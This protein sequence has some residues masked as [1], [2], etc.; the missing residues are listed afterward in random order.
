MS[1]RVSRNPVRSPE[2]LGDSSNETGNGRDFRASVTLLARGSCQHRWVC[3]SGRWG[4]GAPLHAGP[5]LLLRPV[6]PERHFDE[7]GSLNPG[8]IR[9]RLRR[10][11]ERP[12]RGCGASCRFLGLGR[13]VASIQ[14]LATRFD[15][16]PRVWRGRK[17]SGVWSAAPR[18]ATEDAKV[19]SPGAEC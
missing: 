14:G 9:G 15:L 17:R 13:T 3:R 11:R 12:V 16:R 6:W 10:R 19:P 2:P 5:I 7:C 18:T 4:S 1:V 8:W